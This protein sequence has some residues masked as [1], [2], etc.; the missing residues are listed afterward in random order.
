MCG[1]TE[2]FSVQGDVGCLW[3]QRERWPVTV[4]FVASAG[5]S[6]G[7]LQHIY[8]SIYLSFYLSIYLSILSCILDKFP[9]SGLTH[10]F[11]PNTLKK[12]ILNIQDI[13]ITCIYQ[14]L[15]SALNQL[16]SA[17]FYMVRTRKV[18]NSF[19]R[20]N[21]STNS[22]LKLKTPGRVIVF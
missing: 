19:V 14:I 13:N 2:G 7:H 5:Q 21:L 16:E 12:K 11:R 1:C 9:L 17:I 20:W 4:T 10:F 15:N 18:E 3:F 8:L 6:L 22:A